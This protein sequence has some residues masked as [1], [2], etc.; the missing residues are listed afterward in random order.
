MSTSVE[1]EPHSSILTKKVTGYFFQV[2][3]NS[4]E[5][6]SNGNTSN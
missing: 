6:F 3:D 4:F 2:N 5:E 1:C